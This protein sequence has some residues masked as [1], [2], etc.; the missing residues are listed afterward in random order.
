MQCQTTYDLSSWA[1]IP[2]LCTDPDYARSRHLRVKKQ[3]ELFIIRYDKDQLLTQRLD[4]GMGLFRSVVSDGKNILAFS[5]P[6]AVE[7][8]QDLVNVPINEPDTG[9]WKNDVWD[10]VGIPGRVEEFV[11]GTM[12]NVFWNPGSRDWEL[13]TRS[14]IGARNMFYEDSGKTFR[15]MFLEA[16]NNTTLEFADLE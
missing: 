5:P 15:Y 6:K 11:E 9:N 14:C 3:G 1:D 2:R 10:G 13:S 12:V 4:E 8:P 16:M 7:F